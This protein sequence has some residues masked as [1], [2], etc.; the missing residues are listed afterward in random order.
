M[1][2]QSTGANI[3]S[4]YNLHLNS[5]LSLKDIYNMLPCHVSDG[6]TILIYSANKLQIK[7]QFEAMAEF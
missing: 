1:A 5:V 2:I 7:G 4:S 3:Q 6:V